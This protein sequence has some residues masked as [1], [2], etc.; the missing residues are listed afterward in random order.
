MCIRDS[1]SALGAS[2]FL[3][4]ESFSIYGGNFLSTLAG[5]FGYSLSFALGFLF[6]GMMH[7]AI[8]KGSK[9]NWLFILNCFILMTIALSHVLTTICLLVILPWL[10]LENRKVRNIWY[11]ICL[12]YTSDA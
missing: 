4:T 12:L 3:F 8:E 2:L 5:E 9:F 6:I 7:L 1:L 10:L 11:M